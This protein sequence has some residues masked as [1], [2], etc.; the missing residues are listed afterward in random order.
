MSPLALIILAAAATELP[1]ARE[2]YEGGQYEQCVGLLRT[3]D[4]RDGHLYSAL[5]HFALGQPGDAARH[6]NRVL[7]LDAGAQLPAF[8]PPKVVAFFKELKEQRPA[9]RA[10][11]A[12]AA[13]LY[14]QGNVAGAAEQLRLLGQ[15]PLDP[16]TEVRVRMLEGAL[17]LEQGS[18]EAADSAWRAALAL[19]P[20]ARFSFKASAAAQARWLQLQHPVA[21]PAPKWPRVVVPAVAG[22][23]LLVTGGVFYGVARQGADELRVGDPTIRDADALSRKNDTIRAEQT[24]GFLLGGAGLVALGT[25][26][27]LWLTGRD[28]TP[29]TVLISSQ[30]AMV[31]WSTALP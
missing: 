13:A 10:D 17:A 20:G 14:E 26:G 30:G 3:S 23:A 7:D 25:A 5:C 1:S 12:T 4:T 27:V 19:D 21:A 24:V 15:A 16:G 8:S 29:V 31:L 18:A 2:A 22:A 6:F 28:E 9:P 11:V